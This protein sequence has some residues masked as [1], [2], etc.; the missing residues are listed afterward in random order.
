MV[1]QLQQGFP[2]LSQ[3]KRLTSEQSKSNLDSGVI[4]ASATSHFTIRRVHMV[5]ILHTRARTD[6]H[7][8]QSQPW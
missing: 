2:S 3:Q 7:V 6:V 5:R 1:K 8:T 4:K